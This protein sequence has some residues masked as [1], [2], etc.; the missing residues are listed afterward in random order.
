MSRQLRNRNRNIQ[1]ILSNS[2]D[3]HFLNT[4]YETFQYFQ[5]WYKLLSI[6]RNTS[7]KKHKQN[8]TK[9]T[10]ISTVTCIHISNEI[11][12]QLFIQKLS[13]C[14]LDILRNAYYINNAL[15]IPCL[16]MSYSIHARW[17][18]PDELFVSITEQ[19]LPKMRRQI[20]CFQLSYWKN[21]HVIIVV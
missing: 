11:Q 6:K 14:V 15:L 18:N 10:K 7:S 9:Q 8:N 12:P 2:I 4:P 19:Y 16:I 1:R 5:V 21:I 13:L 3:L 20:N 17:L